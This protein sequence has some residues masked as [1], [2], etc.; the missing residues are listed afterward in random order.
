[1]I[2]QDVICF[3]IFN[4]WLILINC[5]VTTDLTTSSTACIT[6]Q[7]INYTL[8]EAQTGIMFA[9]LLNTSLLYSLL[10][11]LDGQQGGVKS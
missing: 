3:L 11:S 9:G 8:L 2:E 5:R 1:M 6:R 10:F 7:K 4:F